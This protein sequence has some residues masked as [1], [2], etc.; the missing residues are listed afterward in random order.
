MIY[1]TS[2][3]RR[4]DR[5][6]PQEKAYYLLKKGEYGTLSMVSEEDTGYG[7][8]IN[9][10]YDDKQDCIYFH[11]AMEG[12]KLRCLAKNNRV[13][14]CIIGKTAVISNQFTT[15]Y[16]SVVVNGTMDIHLSDQ[17]RR[18]GLSLLLDKYCPNDKEIGLRYIEKS[19]HRTNVIRLNIF[20]FSGKSKVIK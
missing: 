3:I 4:Q 12:K 1:D 8:P 6:L 17:E 7:I 20:S 16:E 2:N 14:F 9:F 15:A 18:Y 5:L 19:F 11:C 10:V 13:S